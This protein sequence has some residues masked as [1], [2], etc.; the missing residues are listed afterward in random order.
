MAKKLNEFISHVKNTGLMRTARY[1]LVLP[2]RNISS[3]DSAIVSMLCDQVQLPG[4]NY[5]TTPNLSY[6]ETREIP[7]TRLFDNITISLFVD[8]DM[9]TKR[10]FDDWML[11]IQNPM[12]RTFNYYKNYVSDVQIFVENLQ[13]DTVYAITLHECY[14][15]TISSIQLDYASKEVMKFTVSLA[16]KNWELDR[17]ITKVRR[18]AIRSA[19]DRNFQYP[20][21]QS[22]STGV[23]NNLYSS[24]E[25]ALNMKFNSQQ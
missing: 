6:G 4:L 23:T 9:L 25:N 21:F 8:N 12:N 11:S 5:S 7:Y 24:T 22:I 19:I 13:D 16:Y 14:P 10:Y 17:S 3:S 1:T 15:K 2:Q 18:D 20:E